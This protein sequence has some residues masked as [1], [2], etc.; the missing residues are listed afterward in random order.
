MLLLYFVFLVCMNVFFKMMVRVCNLMLY[1]DREWRLIADENNSRRMVYLRFLL[2]LLWLIAIATVIG[3]WL[4]T[5]RDQYSVAFVL[6]KIVLLWMSISIGLY[7]AAFIVTEIMALQTEQRNHHRTFAL[8]VYSSGAACL[9]VATVEL[10][11]FFNELLVLAFYSC[12][13]YWRGIQYLIEIE[14]EK[15]VIYT[16]LSFIIMALALLLMFFF[17]GNVLRAILTPNL[18]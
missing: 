10:F 8:M 14:G 3:T 6:R 2:P 9:V 4:A 13:L 18:I 15:Q 12:Y 1:P 16:L 17:F 7:F 11:P 5:P